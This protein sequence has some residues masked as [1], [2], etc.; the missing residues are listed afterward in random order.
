LAFIRD[1]G[2]F[3]YRLNPNGTRDTTFGSN[4]IVELV[5]N[6]FSQENIVEMI[7][8]SDGK[9]LLVGHVLGS[10]EFFLARLTETGNWDKTFGRVGVLRVPFGPGVTGNVARALLQP[11]GKILLSGAVTS[12]DTDVWMARFRPNG[13]RDETF[14]TNGVVVT[15]FA[16]GATDAAR[17]ITLSPDGKIR[18]VG[19][20][21]S[22]ANFLVSRFSASGVFEE[23]TSIPFT[24][25]QFA[26]AADVTLQ[27]DG[28]LIVVGRTKNPLPTT[29]GSVFAIAR[30]TE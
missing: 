15:D 19:I 28:K 26:E 7:A 25:S 21:G 23:S 27:S 20:I 29:T 10:P 9:I 16:P 5:F 30:L 3:L 13:R 11:D 6:K 14:G 4:G 18:L 8:L 1:Q 24:P 22:P 12:S 2:L 17:S